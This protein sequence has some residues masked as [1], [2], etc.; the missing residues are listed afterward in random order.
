MRCACDLSAI[1]ER[2][3]RARLLVYCV[4]CDTRSVA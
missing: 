3:E 4:V 2:S 1:P